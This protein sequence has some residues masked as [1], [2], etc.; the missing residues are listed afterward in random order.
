[1]TAPKVFQEPGVLKIQ[2]GICVDKFYG[3]I[4]V[5]KFATFGYFWACLSLGNLSLTSKNFEFVS[6]QQV[7]PFHCVTS[8]CR[9]GCWRCRHG[10]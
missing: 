6:Q 3:L 10:E 2:F 9:E 1:M 8:H 7:K 4:S 5:K